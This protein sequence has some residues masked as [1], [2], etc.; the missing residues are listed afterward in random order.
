MRLLPQPVDNR[1]VTLTSE[2]NLP[3]KFR[4]TALRN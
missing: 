3:A 2:T 1:E 4:D